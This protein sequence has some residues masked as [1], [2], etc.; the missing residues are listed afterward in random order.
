MRRACWW[1]QS[2][3]RTTFAIAVVMWTGLASL[4]TIDPN[5]TR[6][7]TATQEIT[8]TAAEDERRLRVQF[9]SDGV[10]VYVTVSVEPRLDLALLAPVV[11][12]AGAADSPLTQETGALTLYCGNNDLDC[13]E[14]VVA[15][16]R[17]AQL[18]QLTA[19]VR[20]EAAARGDYDE[21]PRRVELVVTGE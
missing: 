9:D 1:H 10:L 2:R 13:G 4:A 17:G 5:T 8:L 14:T 19:T 18:G 21:D 15:V 12:D 6:Q 7:V 11:P 16:R 3:L 20:V